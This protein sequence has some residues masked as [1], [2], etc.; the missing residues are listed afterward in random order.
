MSVCYDSCRVSGSCT[1]HHHRDTHECLLLLVSCLRVL[2][3][4]PP[5]EHTW[6]SATIRVVSQGPA[7]TTTIG[8][9]MSV[10]YDS[11]RVSGSCT[12]HHHWNTHEC[13]LRLV[14]CLR[15]LHWPPPLEHTWVSATTRVVS[16]GPAL[17]TTIGTHMNVCYDS[18]RVSGSCTDHHHWDTHECLLRLVSCLRVMHWPPPSGHTWMSATT[19]VVSQGPALTTTIGTHMSV[20]YDSCRVSGS[21][22]DHHHRDTHECLLWLVSC[23]R[24]LHWPPPLEHTCMSTMTRVV[25]QGSRIPEVFLGEAVSR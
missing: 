7:L 16:Q 11:C 1:D 17:T 15:V 25:S 10:C 8:T 21:C 13:L 14:S 12:D 18:C 2:H 3:W 23:L 5:L 24:V 22:T 20:C 9:H 19:R 6:M 4:P